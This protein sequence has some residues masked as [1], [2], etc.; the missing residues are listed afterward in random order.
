MKMNSQPAKMYELL[1]LKIRAQIN[2]LNL[3]LKD[4]AALFTVATNWKQP[5]CSLVDEWIK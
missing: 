4:F 5:K 3:H 2:N 1:T